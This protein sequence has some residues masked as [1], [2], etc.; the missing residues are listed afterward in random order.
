MNEVCES[1]LFNNVRTKKGLAYSV[2]GEFGSAYDHP[3]VFNYQL[4]PKAELQLVQLRRACENW[5]IW[6]A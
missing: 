3:G 6:S 5:T 4:Q 2:S 1:R